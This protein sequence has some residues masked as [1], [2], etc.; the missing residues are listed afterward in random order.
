M[1]L[2]RA[3]QDRAEAR[4]TIG[5]PDRAGSAALPVRPAVRGV[6][7]RAVGWSVVITAIVVRPMVI[8]R[9]SNASGIARAREC[10]ERGAGL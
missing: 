10:A 9:I 8:L 1:L 4:P 2:G 5:A 6:G 7:V 3:A